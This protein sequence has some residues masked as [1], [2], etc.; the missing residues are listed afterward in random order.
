MKKVIFK[1]LGKEYN[2]FV[3]IRDNYLAVEYFKKITR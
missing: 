3:S 2:E 1:E